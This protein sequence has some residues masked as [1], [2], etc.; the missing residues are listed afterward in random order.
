MIKILAVEFEDLGFHFKI[1]RDNGD[2]LF[3]SE[4]YLTR[5]FCRTAVDSFMKSCENKGL[6]VL[7][8]R[9]YSE[10]GVVRKFFHFC[11]CDK[12]GRVLGDSDRFATDE[13]R[14]ECIQFLRKNIKKA[15]FDK[16]SWKN[17]AK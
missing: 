3:S 17:V 15:R 2:L 7:D 16:R 10:R 4:S 13:A 12:W 8:E 9:E 5:V 1:E 6:F 14:E 11:V